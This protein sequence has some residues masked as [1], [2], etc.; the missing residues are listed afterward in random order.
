MKRFGLILLLLLSQACTLD[1]NC[2]ENMDVLVYCDLYSYQT[3]QA[4]SV[5][6]FSVRGLEKDSMLYDDANG[7]RQLALPLKS[8][9]QKTAFLLTDILADQCDTLSF[10]HSNRQWFVSMECGCLILHTLSEVYHRGNLIDSVSLINDEVKNE[11][12]IHVKIYL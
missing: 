12:N 3:K 6:R 1:R 9:A 11:K 2:Y 5:E 4:I 8:N 7:I 10:I